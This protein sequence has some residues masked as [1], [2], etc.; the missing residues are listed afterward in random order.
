MATAPTHPLVSVIIP[1]YNHGMYLPEAFA[2]IWQ[3]EYP[4]VEIIV[5]D[6]GSSDTT[7]Q[8]AQSY[9]G[10]QYIYQ[11]NQ[12]LSAA[13]NT[14]IA[15]STGQYLL[16]LD[17]D[18]WLLPGALLTNV[19]YLQQQ[20]ELAF[21]SGGHDKVFT[22]TGVVRVETK[23]L[24]DNH[25][26]Q[27]LQG[28]YIGMHA[29]VL[30]QRW[31]FAELQFDI[32]LKACEDYD[33]YLRLA[34]NHPV[35]HH[36]ER[37]AAYRLHDTNM[38]GNIAL[39]LRTVLA[40]LERQQPYLRSPAEHAAL[41]HGQAIWKDYYGWALYQ[42]LQTTPGTA[43]ELTL[44]ASLK[45][46]L[47]LRS[48]LPSNAVMLKK[49][50]KKCTPN[51]GLRLLH[52]A[53]I[54]KGYQPAIGRVL[55]GDFERTV[56]FSKDFG[57]DRGGPVDR[58]YIEQFLQG[59][60]AA[61]RGRVLEIGDNEYTLRFGQGVT[62]SDI[63]HINSDNKQATFIGDLSNAPHISDNLFD[64]LILTQTLQMIYDYKEALATCHRILK[65][66]GALLITVPGISPLD[67]GE[68]RTTWYWSFTDNA[69]RRLLAE[70]FPAAPLEFQSYGNVFIA[71]A[72][73][74]G[75]GVSEVSPSQLDNYDPQY[76]VINAA[77]AVKAPLD[78]RPA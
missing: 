68:W 37:I 60:A 11:A 12:G 1:C 33:V 9:P 44:L 63:L 52:R 36:T 71:S 34:R 6:D 75:M 54:Y 72:F 32:T 48:L 39:M 4:A 49:L 77:K 25:Y 65:P 56:P 20:P 51:A 35:A 38:S 7:R 2:S 45:P 40:V 5:V 46:T 29:T 42:K 19:L 66:G 17:A 59:H 74:Y 18:D 23:A 21:V 22:A 24:T 57:Y 30:Y 61:I 13:R 70:T 8:V 58:Y 53:G 47:F 67:A 55:L 76:Q 69:L 31:A 28:N 14:G 15:H 64:C 27:L 62:Q 16:F 73:L 41:E 43:A 10:I 78:A 50:L 3:Q 26:I